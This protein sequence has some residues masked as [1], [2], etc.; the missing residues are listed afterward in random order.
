MKIG[1]YIY[2]KKYEVGEVLDIQNNRTGNPVLIIAK[3]K[4]GQRRL[5]LKFAS[6]RKPTAEELDKYD[7]TILSERTIESGFFNQ[8][9]SKI[10][11]D[12]SDKEIQKI[13]KSLNLKLPL[14]Y[15]EFL[16]DFPIEI[17]TFKRE[18]CIA[19]EKLNERYLRNSVDSIIQVNRFFECYELSNLFAIGDNGAGL[20]YVINLNGTTTKVY[21][22]ESG[23]YYSPELARYIH[24]TDENFEKYIEAE[25]MTLTD[26]A[27][28]VIDAAIR[29]YNKG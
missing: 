16:K 26:F 25:A 11:K 7:D 3:F 28:K 27:N 1:D 20:Y 24:L 18:K 19:N 14:F 29:V 12:L 9:D 5:M 21:S 6:L 17:A 4:T 22:V 10:S 15:K 8:L 13:E 2:H 23:G